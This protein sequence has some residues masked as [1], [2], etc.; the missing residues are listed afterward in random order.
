MIRGW[1]NSNSTKRRR[2]RSF[3]AIAEAR[4]EVR[5]KGRLAT[6]EPIAPGSFYTRPHNVAPL[7]T[8]DRGVADEL[9]RHLAEQGLMTLAE[10]IDQLESLG[11]KLAKR[12]ASDDTVSELVYEM[13]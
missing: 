9:R 12:D 3:D 13:H 6:S 11:Q 2:E 5:S 4:S 1:T 7:A 8:F 10:Q